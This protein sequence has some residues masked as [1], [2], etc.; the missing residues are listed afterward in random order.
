MNPAKGH[1][2]GEAARKAVL[3]SEQKGGSLRGFWQALEEGGRHT[4]VLAEL[5]LETRA[6][7]TDLPPASSWL[8]SRFLA[9]L[10]CVTLDLYGRAELRAVSRRGIALSTARLMRTLTEGLL[11]LWGPRPETLFRHVDRFLAGTV[12]GST[13]RAESVTEHGCAVVIEFL[14]ARDVPLAMAE[15]AAGALEAIFDAC[16]SRGSIEPMQ[17]VTGTPF[18]T[19]R[20]EARW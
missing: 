11:R 16:G 4:A 14:G 6:V 10:Q 2:P 8:P 13:V 18:P 17:W 7:C 1:R 5:S 19:A 9:E 20:A 12:R 3:V 15:G